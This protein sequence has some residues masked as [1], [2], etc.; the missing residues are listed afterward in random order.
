MTDL[1]KD[2]L[3]EVLLKF[4]EYAVVYGDWDEDALA[5]AK[6]AITDKLREARI[7][8]LLEA[9]KLVDDIPGSTPV[10]GGTHRMMLHKL[11][12]NRIAELKGGKI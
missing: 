10:T 12:D 3:D 6:Q 11:I 9:Q 8:G 7:D 2:W 5:E 1:T 4:G